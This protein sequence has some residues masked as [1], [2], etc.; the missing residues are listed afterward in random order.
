MWRKSAQVIETSGWFQY[1][2]FQHV[3]SM[4]HIR[5]C[6]LKLNHRLLLK[7]Q[8]SWA[9]SVVTESLSSHNEHSVHVTRSFVLMTCIYRKNWVLVYR[10]ATYSQLAHSNAAAFS[11]VV[12]SVTQY[13]TL[14]TKPANRW[15]CFTNATLSLLPNNMYINRQNGVIFTWYSLTDALTA[16]LLEYDSTQPGPTIHEKTK[17]QHD[18]PKLSALMLWVEMQKEHAHIHGKQRPLQKNCSF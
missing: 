1:Y 9:R 18:L 2:P 3:C 14:C 5:L 11:V 10:K 12:C 13:P 15:Q 7:K 6:A 16:S 8:I 4:N 17:N